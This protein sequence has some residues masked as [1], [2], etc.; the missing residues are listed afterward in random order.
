M[1][2][3][4]VYLNGDQLVKLYRRRG[5]SQQDLANR[6]GLDTRTIA[7]VRRGGA[8]DASTLQLLSLALNVAPEQLLRDEPEIQPSVPLPAPDTDSDGEIGWAPHFAIQQVWR[9]ID[10][11]TPYSH[12]DS[13]SGILCEWYRI[14]KL[15]DGDTPIVFPYLTWGAGIECLSRPQGTE[16]HKVPIQPGDL[17]H[18]EKQ[19]ELSVRPPKGPKGTLFECGPFQLRFIE[20]FHGEGQQWWQTRIAYSIQSM[21]IQILFPVAQPCRQ[22]R[23]TC[24][25]PGQRKFSEIGRD[26]P[27]RL[28]DGSVVNWHIQRPPIGAFYKIDWTW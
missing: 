16:W 9:T 3:R 11:R 8:C 21:V 18:S 1:R 25:M 5:W 10:L 27:F 7:K 23:A 13:P 24:A 20:A 22:V 12:G 6:A 26:D 15:D 14:C 4:G 19:W 2:K 17:V 28:P